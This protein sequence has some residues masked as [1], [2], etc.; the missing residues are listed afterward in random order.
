MIAA[1]ATML[2]PIATAPADVIA[3]A[4]PR[5]DPIPKEAAIAIANSWG[6]VKSRAFAAA[7]GKL[8]VIPSAL[9]QF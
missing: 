9:G 2:T 8:F 1:P 4:I 7:A 6:T 3:L 5:E